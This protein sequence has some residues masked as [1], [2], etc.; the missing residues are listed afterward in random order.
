MCAAHDIVMHTHFSSKDSSDQKIVI[1]C[2]MEICP[3]YENSKEH[4]RYP[5]FGS[6]TST[7]HTK[8]SACWIFASNLFKQNFS[9]ILH[10]DEVYSIFLHF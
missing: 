7:P 4:A 2:V 1:F 8:I 6:L 3:E 10:T 9:N 5:R